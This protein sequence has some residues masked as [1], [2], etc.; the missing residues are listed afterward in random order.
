MPMNYI[1]HKHFVNIALERWRK[2][3]GERNKPT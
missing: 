1:M 3:V 2:S